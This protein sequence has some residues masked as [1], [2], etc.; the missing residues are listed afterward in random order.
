[1]G[2][3]SSEL[4]LPV[5]TD[6]DISHTSSALV[7]PEIK[8]DKETQTC[9]MSAVM[10]RKTEKERESRIKRKTKPQKDTSNINEGDNN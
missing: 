3:T 7:N 10:I 8:T 1:M 2:V 5:D 4:L 6:C 9:L